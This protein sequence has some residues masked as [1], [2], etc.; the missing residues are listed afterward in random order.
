[1]EVVVNLNESDSGWVAPATV[2]QILVAGATLFLAF[3]TLRSVRAASQSAD[4]TA[5]LA[6]AA[7]RE[8][9]AAHRQ[10][11]LAEKTM[12][13]SIQ[14]VLSDFAK[15]PTHGPM[16]AH[17]E[18]LPNDSVPWAGQDD[19]RAARLQSMHIW[20][21][22]MLLQAPEG[23]TGRAVAT[24][25]KNVGN[26]AAIVEGVSLELDGRPSAYD[27]R[28]SR[29]AIARD[30]YCR[31][32]FS[33]IDND[34]P[35]PL[36][37]GGYGVDHAEPNFFIDIRYSNVSGSGRRRTRQR[38]QIVRLKP[39][40]AGLEIWDEESGVCLAAAQYTE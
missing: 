13:A 1:V 25:F 34:F 12:L 20:S 39:Y 23:V 21:N 31:V 16:V 24:L 18:W 26:G 10:N 29:L 28:I 37:G 40:I 27:T 17:S 7:D 6:E 35:D 36:K 32:T 19:E 22:S 2:A 30:E 8:V 38:I 4:A 9:A 11:E 3:F 5:K 33:V 14:P 15:R